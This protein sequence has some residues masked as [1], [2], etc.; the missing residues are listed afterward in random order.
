VSYN[1]FSCTFRFGFSFYFASYLDRDAGRPK[2]KLLPR[3]AT[4]PI[5]A[6]AE[7][8]QSAAIFGKARPRE[9]KAAEEGGSVQ[10]SAVES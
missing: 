6:L 1:Q 5:N 10:Q 4:E 8:L 9:E 3:T 7:T 2:L